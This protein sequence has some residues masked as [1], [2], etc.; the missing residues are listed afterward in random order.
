MNHMTTMQ[1]KIDTIVKN[2]L[3]GMKDKIT[4][5]K[6]KRDQYVNEKNAI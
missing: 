4:A 5:L 6:T 2:A 3:Y 1:K